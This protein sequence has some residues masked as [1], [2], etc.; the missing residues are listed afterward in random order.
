M[1]EKLFVF[2]VAFFALLSFFGVWLGYSGLIY[3]VT[4]AFSIIVSLVVSFLLV[5]RMRFKKV[6]HEKKLVFLLL[7][8]LSVTIY[9]ALPY[10]VFPHN[11]SDMYNH[12]RSVRIVSL[13][14]GFDIPLNFPYLFAHNYPQMYYGVVSQF[15]SLFG[16]TYV[17]NTVIPIFF[18]LMSIVGLFFVARKLF[19][20]KVALISVFIAS[21]LIT[22]LWHLEQGYFPQL[23]AQMF[24]VSGFYFYL[25]KNK[26]FL[27][28]SMVGLLSY[29]HY[30]AVI[31]G[32]LV[33]EFL[34]FRKWIIFVYPLIAMILVLPES[35]GLFTFWLDNIERIGYLFLIRGGVFV[36]NI[37]ALLIFLFSVYGFFVLC[38]RRRVEQASNLLFNLMLPIVL[39]MIATSATFMLNYVFSL[40]E[41]R[42]VHQLYTAV[43]MFYLFLLPLSIVAAYGVWKLKHKF[44]YVVIFLL[45]VHFL[46]YAGYS[47]VLPAHA[48]YGQGFYFVTESLNDVSGEF[49]VRLDDSVF[50]KNVSC[51]D[52]F[53]YRSFFDNPDEGCGHCGYIEIGRIFQF[54]WTSYRVVN[55]TFVTFDSKNESVVVYGDESADYVVTEE[56]LDLGVVG[57]FAGFYLY[58]FE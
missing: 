53:L 54:P 41:L 35:L 18:E 2:F 16:Y 30:F 3:P 46:Y 26:R 14:H 39:L 48:N 40:F 44:F 20:E 25:V 32:F 28:L 21:F 11:C 42:Q 24:L 22:N 45:G 38:K 55:G 34:K 49:K 8:F 51:K 5:R 6:K 10:F 31:L 9:P 17:L 37:F 47:Y 29:P 52:G 1:I 33:L 15:Y 7:L 43:K 4:S 36:P 23:M 12:A 57:S 19:D 27:L 58:R 13:N 50:S 56:I